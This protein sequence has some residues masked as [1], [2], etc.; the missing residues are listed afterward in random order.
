M[1][2]VTI[3]GAGSTLPDGTNINVARQVRAIIANAMSSTPVFVA[4]QNLGGA[5]PS[6]PGGQTGLVV[7][8]DA[9]SRN[10]DASH[11]N[12]QYFVVGDGTVGGGAGPVTVAG[13][14]QLN[15]AAVLGTRA[16]TFNAGGGSGTIVGGDGPKTINIGAGTNF[17]VY[18]GAGDDTISL[19]SSLAFGRNTVEAGF[20]VTKNNIALGPAPTLVRSTGNDVV[21]VGAGAATIQVVGMVQDTVSGGSGSLTFIDGTG[22]SQVNYVTDPNTSV[23]LAVASSGS[24]T[25]I[26]GAGAGGLYRGGTSGSNLLVGGLGA[27]TMQG[28]GNGDVL[29][30]TSS[31]GLQVLQAGAGNETLLGSLSS[32][33]NVFSAGSGNDLIIAGAGNDRIN[34]GTGSATIT[35]GGGGDLFVFDPRFSARAQ[36]VITDFTPGTD[37]VVLQAYSAPNTAAT[38]AASALRVGA[39]A[40]KV[41]L[42]DGTTITFQGITSV[43]SSFFA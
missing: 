16:V 25:V 23:R 5:A 10:I 3:G 36:V 30:A 12:Y 42:S 15:Q 39:S 8:G 43:N 1:A 6:V 4:D 20:A 40:S 41:T 19:T 18:T 27:V 14:G 26:G 34:A 2:G 31:V 28:A 38:L 32:S 24:A 13:A 29:I 7:V 17:A 22:G 35:G 9:L 21:S 37:H 11:F 33:D